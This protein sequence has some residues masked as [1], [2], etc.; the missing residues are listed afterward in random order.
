[1]TNQL[2]GKQGVY[3]FRS[4]IGEYDLPR[5]RV[6]W[7]ISPEGGWVAHFLSVANEADNCWKAP[8]RLLQK[9]CNTIPHS[10]FYIETMTG[11]LPQDWGDFAEVLY[12]SRRQAEESSPIGLPSSD[13]EQFDC[14][15][16][17]VRCDGF[18]NFSQHL[19]SHIEEKCVI[20]RPYFPYLCE[21]CGRAYRNRGTLT[22]HLKDHHIDA[23]KIVFTCWICGKT[24]KRLRSLQ[25]HMRDHMCVAETCE[26]CGKS[27]KSERSMQAH[28][29][30]HI[31]TVTSIE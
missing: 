5:L 22:Q 14:V 10:S 27:C 12:S 29:R 7:T 19:T 11:D 28:K 4:A 6:L 20:D 24:L 9:V 8:M 30:R 18:F 23:E 25:R 3:E 21:K 16:C 31:K 15:V 17:A 1:M 26:Y 13:L 2:F